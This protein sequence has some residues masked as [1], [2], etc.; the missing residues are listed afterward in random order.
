MKGRGNRDLTVHTSTSA[1]IK[2]ERLPITHVE[3]HDFM[4]IF[5]LRSSFHHHMIHL[6]IHLSLPLQRLLQDS[7]LRCSPTDCGGFCWD[8]GVG[9]CTKNKKCYTGDEHTQHS[10]RVRHHSAFVP[11]LIQGGSTLVKLGQVVSTRKIKNCGQPQILV[12]Q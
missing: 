1:I 7:H 9:R 11:W 5:P 8:S 6:R 4:Q 2:K 12:W 3:Q 10:S